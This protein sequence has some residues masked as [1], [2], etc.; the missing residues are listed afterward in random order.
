MNSPRE[1]PEPLVVIC[2]R[3][4]TF[5][6]S[7]QSRRNKRGCP[8]CSRKRAW[9][10]E[11]DLFTEMPHLSDSW[12]F[13]RNAHLDP[14]TLTKGSD[15][16]AWWTCEKGHEFEK[17]IYEMGKS[18]CGYCSN[19][20]LLV[21]FNDLASVRPD[22]AAEFDVSKNGGLTPQDLLFGTSKKV[23]WRCDA[24]HSFEAK[25]SQRNFSGSGC[26]VCKGKRSEPGYNDL[27][28]KYPEVAE[29][30]D[31]ELNEG[32]TPENF[33]PTSTQK[34]WW[35]C[36]RG[37]SWLMRIGD[38]VTHKQGCAVCANRQVVAGVN[39]LL[40]LAP[41]VAAT[42]DPELNP[43]DLSSRVGLHSG[44][45]AWWRCS[46]GHV[47]QATVGSRQKSGCPICAGQRVLAGYNDLE[48][49]NPDA[50]AHFL[51]GKNGVTPSEVLVSSRIQYWWECDLGHNFKAH[52]D[53]VR[54]GNWCPYCGGKKLLMGFNDL[55]TVRPDIAKQWHPTKNAE[56]KP[57]QVINGFHK[58]VWWLCDAGHDYLQSGKKRRVGQGCP[59]CAPSGF[60]PSNAA[61]LYFIEQPSLLSY[62]VGITSAD[63]QNRLNAFAQDGWVT[64]AQIWFASGVDA[65]ATEEK[66]FYDL[67]HLRS[68]PAY[69]SN[70]DMRRTGGW[71]ETF[72][73][74]MI[75]R[76]A[77]LE[78][79]IQFAKDSRHAFEI[80]TNLIN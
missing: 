67:R 57:S 43:M 39:D 61:H 66:F 15:K 27:K 4:H 56:L 49:Q 33:S 14:L 77:V 5:E 18:G 59:S 1:T 31:L 20:K 73:S 13:A 44:A 76:D 24:G 47:Y 54:K 17:S 12:N 68:I 34:V 64:H 36:P 72:S 28:T 35:K 74:S 79:L 29:S 48:S 65:L 2:E 63:S 70:D 30:W 42:L 75:S 8:F 62:K 16:Q 3:G 7:L 55:E 41:E 78:L 26:A 38:R 80:R 37:H 69:L 19:Q 21:G 45:M 22:L 51:Q 53:S 23:W 58:K 32:L 25:V 50:A 71:T 11:T 6:Q 10:G 60:T 40:T 52:P 9:P 46:E